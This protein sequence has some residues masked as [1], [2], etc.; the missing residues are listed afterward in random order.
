M[1][2]VVHC[3]TILSVNKRLNCS[4]MFWQAGYFQFPHQCS[5]LPCSRCPSSLWGFLPLSP[6]DYTALLGSLHLPLPQTTS[7]L[8]KSGAAA[9]KN[10]KHIFPSWQTP[11]YSEVPK[12]YTTFSCDIA[13]VA[14]ADYLD[15]VLRRISLSCSMKGL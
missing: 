11:L 4:R 7:Y 8:T 14:I 15:L 6:I 1:F 13:L 9:I 3:C 2:L 12:F 5:F 10:L